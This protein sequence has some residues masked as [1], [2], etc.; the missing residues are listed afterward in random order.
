MTR[1]VE[2]RQSARLA[3]CYPIRLER[4]GDAGATLLERT[5]TRNIAARGAYF[6]TFQAGSFSVGQEV[7]VVVSVPH[8]LSGDGR[9]VLLDL[10]GKGRIVRLEDPQV[11]GCYG[12][13]GLSLTGVAIEFAGPRS[14]QYR[15]AQA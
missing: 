3:L 10:S 11:H 4:D 5:V 1:R 12:E 6:S 14:F 2:Q 15:W 8:R 9:E 13:D 7:R